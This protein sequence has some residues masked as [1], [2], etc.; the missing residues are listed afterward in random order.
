MHC[1]HTENEN[2]KRAKLIFSINFG[3]ILGSLFIIRYPVVC[4]SLLRQSEQF[5]QE[6]CQIILHYNS[7]YCHIMMK[8]FGL[9]GANTKSYAAIVIVTSLKREKPI[10]SSPFASVVLCF[11][12]SFNQGEGVSDPQKQATSPTQRSNG[13]V[14][15]KTGIFHYPSAYVD[16][17]ASNIISFATT[18]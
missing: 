3:I 8:S 6:P 18:R 5:N 9:F 14:H 11:L 7:M 2:N 16:N 4:L 13:R 17:K 12:L 15:Q 10:A 1:P